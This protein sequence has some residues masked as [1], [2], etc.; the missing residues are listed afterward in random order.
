MS[1][2]EVLKLQACHPALA[3]IDCFKGQTTPKIL[4]LLRQ[5]NVI[6]LIVP[7]NCTD[8]LQPI[9]V[10]INK[11]V[12]HQMRTRFQ[13]WY[14]DEVQRQLKEMPINKIRIDL[15]APVVKTN[16]ARWLIAAV[17]NLQERP[18][19]AINGFKESGILAA[20]D[21]VID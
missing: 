11:P 6:P 21:A 7:A 10:S 9:D 20:V 14:A 19:V 13:S 8:K 16:C 12:E 1:Q 17:Q 5:N 2:R 4:T 15:T 18:T 3:I